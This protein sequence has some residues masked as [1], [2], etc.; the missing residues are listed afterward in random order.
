MNRDQVVTYLKDHA[1]Q[2]PRPSDAQID[3]LADFFV[4]YYENGD[5]QALPDLR[6]TLDSMGMTPASRAKLLQLEEGRQGES[7]D[8]DAVMA[9]SAIVG[10]LLL[11]G[12]LVLWFYLGGVMP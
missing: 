7:R 12:L 8:L 10:V 4:R 1:P 3:A 6:R 2:S 5:V 9:G 11:C